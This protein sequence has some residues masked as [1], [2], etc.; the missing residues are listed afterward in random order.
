M[1]SSFLLLGFFVSRKLPKLYPVYDSILM[2]YLSDVSSFLSVFGRYLIKIQSSR[3][4]QMIR[5]MLRIESLLY[6]CDR[7]TPHPL[8]GYSCGFQSYLCSLYFVSPLPDSLCRYSRFPLD[9]FDTLAL[10]QPRQHLWFLGGL[11]P[12]LKRMAV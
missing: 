8:R 1:L 4:L 3:F 10:G 6:I 12:L 5:P 11:L 2:D 7:I 9:G